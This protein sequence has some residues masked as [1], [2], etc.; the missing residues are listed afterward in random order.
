MRDQLSYLGLRAAAGLVGALPGWA[1]R[2]LGSLAGRLWHAL[3]R[4][5]RGMAR[6]HMRRVLGSDSEARPAAKEMMRSYGRYY[7]EALWVRP[8]R[9][10]D[11]LERTRVEGLHGIIAARDAGHGMI[12]ALPHIGNWEVASPIALDLDISVVAVAEKLAN[13]R[14]TE[15]FTRMRAD[16]GIEIILATGGA[17]VRRRLEESLAENKAVALLSD[18]D[19]RGRGIEVDFFGEKTTLPAG[20]ARLALKTGAPL[21]PVGTYF[22]GDGHYVEVRPPLP[23]PDASSREDQMKTMTQALAVELEQLILQAPEQWHLVVPNWPSD[24]E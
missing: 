13:Q 15:W 18:R 10:P 20:P 2:S 8:H 3:D 6:S 9:L 1:A 17:E 4:D 21:F 5:R 14:I 19:L 22:E 7:A 12:Y 11:L 24:R 23:V 16:I